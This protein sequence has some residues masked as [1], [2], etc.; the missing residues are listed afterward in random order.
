MAVTIRRLPSHSIDQSFDSSGLLREYQG[1]AK[2]G[3]RALEKGPDLAL[4]RC[5]GRVFYSG[6][7]ASAA[8]GEV[9]SDYLRNEGVRLN[10]I[11]N[12]ILPDDI[13]P[14]D[15]L[16]AVSL[17]GSTEE[18]LIVAERASFL[19]VPVVGLSAGG[20]L[21]ELCLERGLPHVQL[22]R[23]LTSRSSFPL[24][25][26]GVSRVLSILL[27]RGSLLELSANAWRNLDPLAQRIFSEGQESGPVSLA[28]WLLNAPHI[29]IYYSPFAPSV[30]RRM[31]NMLSENAKTRSTSS[32][33]LEVQHDGITAWEGDYGTKLVLIKS[34]YD[35]EFV[36]RRFAAV[37]DVVRSLGFGVEELPG[38]Q[39]GLEYFVNS[40][41]YIDL[42]S[43]YLALL[44]RVDPA[45]TRSQRLVR[46]R[47]DNAP[48]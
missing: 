37:S 22:E 48:A 45:V 8:P 4:R 17:S 9:F 44:K 29:N 46:A 27:G 19:G 20:K 11:T 5:K 23:N 1:W 33:I 40:F 35:D 12:H 18:T 39:G 47:L 25:M 10:L 41:F 38:T 16:V 7:G 2:D 43:I 42:A 14:N 24:L 13:T 26:G 3:L 31:K 32:D 30:G 36:T 6:M 28:K 34:P 21:K 15:T